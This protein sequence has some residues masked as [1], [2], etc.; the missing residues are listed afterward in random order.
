VELANGLKRDR[1]NSQ[2]V[3]FGGFVCD[4]MG[5][6]KTI[7]ALG[8]FMCRLALLVLNLLTTQSKCG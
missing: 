3:P 1:E 5:F 6:G 4:E 7:Q 8:V 2:E